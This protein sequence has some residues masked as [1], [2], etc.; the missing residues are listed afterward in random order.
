MNP[1]SDITIEGFD[2]NLDSDT[3]YIWYFRATDPQ[4]A[5]REFTVSLDEVREWISDNIDWVDD[6][7][8]NDI[9]LKEELDFN[10]QEAFVEEWLKNNK[11]PE[12]VYNTPQEEPVKPP[13]DSSQYARGGAIYSYSGFLGGVRDTQQISISANREKGTARV[14]CV[15]EKPD[16]RKAPLHISRKRMGDEVEKFWKD[17]RPLSTKI[18]SLSV[19]F[20][21]IDWYEN[22]GEY[23][24]GNDGSYDVPVFS[25]KRGLKKVRIEEDYETDVPK[26]WEI[27]V[28]CVFKL[29][30]TKTPYMAF[31]EGCFGVGFTSTNQ[32]KIEKELRKVLQGKK[33]S[34]YIDFHPEYEEGG[35]M[36]FETEPEFDLSDD[37]Y[38]I[39][40][41]KIVGSNWRKEPAL[42]KY[43]IDGGGKINLWKLKDLSSDD[44][45]SLSKTITTYAD[46]GRIG[47][48]I[49]LIKMEDPYSPVEA[50]TEGTI[51]S[52]DDIGQLHIDWDNGRT[53]AIVPEIDEYEL[54]DDEPLTYQVGDKV[55]LS[56]AYLGRWG[57]ESDEPD[58]VITYAW[59]EYYGGH[60]KEHGEDTGERYNIKTIDGN[61]LESLRE[62]DLTPRTLAKGGN[63]KTRYA[64]EADYY[65]YGDDDKDATREAKKIASEIDG[66]YDN[67]ARVKH[68]H[69]QPFGT[70]GSRQVF[71][72]GGEVAPNAKTSNLTPEQQK[73]VRSP[74]FKAWFG[75]SKVVDEKG[76]PLVVY[77]QTQEKFNVFDLDKEQGFG[78]FFWFTADKGQIERGE[79]GASGGEKGKEMYVMPVF[80]SINKI[81]GWNEYDKWQTASELIQEGYDGLKLDNDYIVFSPTQIK[82]ADG[83]NT[84][85]DTNNPDVRFDDG[86]E[87]KTLNDIKETFSKGNQLAKLELDDGLV[88]WFDIKD[89]RIE[90][91]RYGNHSNRQPLY[92]ENEKTF[93]ESV[94]RILAKQKGTTYAD[95]GEVSL[96]F[97]QGSSD[98][99]YHI[100]LEKD[101]GGYLV[102]FQYGRRGS[103][104]KSG[105]KTATPVSLP[106]AQKIYDKLLNSKVAKGYS[107]GATTSQQFSGNP[108]AP[109][110]VH[111]LPQLLNMVFTAKEFINDDSYLAQ[112]KMDGERRMVVT[113]PNGT[114]GLNKK[115]QEVPLPNK[116][117]DSIDDVCT[118][119]GEIIGTRLYAFDILELNGQNLEG[120]PCIER[121]STLNTLKFGDGVKVVGTAYNTE[122]KQELFDKLKREHREGIVF[123][124]KDAPYTHGRPH[125]GGNQLKY[126]FYKTATFIVA[127]ITP[128]KRSVGLELLDNGNMVF[129]GKVTI[130]PNKDI[131]NVGDFVEVRY[132]YAYK[133]GAIFQPTYLSKR[134]DSDLTDATI[135]QI[136]YKSD[137][138]GKGGKVENWETEHWET[139]S[140]EGD[141]E[142]GN[143]FRRMMEGKTSVKKSFEELNTLGER[144]P[145]VDMAKET[146][147]KFIDHTIY[148]MGLEKDEVENIW[149]KVGEEEYQRNKDKYAGGGEIQVKNI[150]NGRIKADLPIYISDD[151]Q[152]AL[153]ELKK[154]GY[155]SLVVGGA[156]RDALSGKIPKDIDIEVYGIRYKDLD[157][158]LSKYGTT[159]IVGKEFGVIK[160]KDSD[161]MEYD[162]S[163]PRRENKKGVGHKGF[164][165]QIDPNMTPKQASKRRDFTWNA[166]A[167]DPIGKIVYDYYGGIK[168]LKNG[169]MRATSEQFPEDS[170]RVLRAMQFQSRSG[171]KIAP[172]TLKVMKEMVKKGMME[173]L[174]KERVS[175]EW[176]K[177]ATKGE[178]PELIFSFL[179]NVGLDCV[180][181]H[182]CKLK[183]VEQDKEWHPEGD[184][185]I[186]TGLVMKEAVRIANREGLEG[187]DRAV[188]M[189]SALT[190]D[191]AK[192]HT[193]KKELKKVKRNGDTVEEFRITAKGHEK[194]GGNLA[195]EFLKSI[196]IKKSIIDRVVPLVE[197]HLSH[198]SIASVQE[199]K[200]KRSATSK[201]ARRLGKSN[202]DEL[203]L[204]IEADTSG[205]PPLKKG[206]P[207]SAE[208]LKK[209]AKSLGVQKE[210]EKDIILGRHLIELGLKP[211]E[212]FTPILKKVREAQETGEFE[213]VEQ[214]KKWVKKKGYKAK[215]GE[216]IGKGQKVYAY[217]YSNDYGNYNVTLDSNFGDKTFGEVIEIQQK[218]K[219]PR[220]S[221]YKI[222][223]D[224]D[225]ELSLWRLDFM[226]ENEYASGGEVIGK[227]HAKGGERFTVKSTGQLVELEGGEGVLKK[228][229]MDSEKEY[230]LKGTPKEIASCLN[231]EYDGVN[232]RDE[233][234]K[235]DITEGSYASGG[236]VRHSSGRK[237]PTDS[238]TWHIEGTK[239]QGNDGNIW[240]VGVNKN[241]IHRWVKCK[242]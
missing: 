221:R 170:L 234:G 84:T 68:L 87:I 242:P 12:L 105:T 171:N 118:I 82:L 178:H 71:D 50:G 189:F 51:R 229:A 18:Q 227:S 77:H 96:F 104:L 109:K 223:F 204:L 35:E 13:P 233:S 159:N 206:L 132:L 8:D 11:E 54:I 74:E 226:L 213:T 108:L 83:T 193:S 61:E 138:M 48:R 122:E 58:G 95:G 185:E 49:R 25:I 34:T 27:R 86:G 230:T 41:G 144:I 146:I 179:R 152:R 15:M 1:T 200:G 5:Y 19:G 135:E 21:H 231:E 88:Y 2:L 91:T 53:L 136:I 38:T 112:E 182:I 72:D 24:G 14:T 194:A 120:E 110:T 224:N 214:G 158:I 67:E 210:P 184:A 176:M 174:S 76:N 47:D 89:L 126:K 168:D 9:Y 42:K 98:K 207:K 117:I 75:D 240:C 150:K 111:R 33:D 37:T 190:H 232:F 149:Y 101:N 78:G 148:Y 100:Q 69:E 145:D 202:I 59:R 157:K 163:V 188:L 167:Y 238:A 4:D 36:A 211:G 7:V 173:E 191:F 222:R 166:L 209:L 31:I 64:A 195:K 225:E 114:M 165:V 60:T 151:G 220:I 113:T 125:S 127:N 198:T 85:F 63:V 10:D 56:P 133:G 241:G 156:V 119:D 141:I 103:A 43:L 192:P 40:L 187:D 92:Y 237:S 123:K 208:E 102:N 177:W 93:Y 160:F 197:N 57:R 153:S 29:T 228:S 181:P 212:R 216:V 154:K 130:P 155:K 80:L 215:G 73:L 62:T 116:I 236:S 107:Q 79:T 46:G 32:K 172:K 218:D 6:D 235:C 139:L 203:L 39:A 161:K 94:N 3:V 26:E 16:N 90:H 239:M 201:L 65:V 199:E 143:I 169:V 217:L 115:G 30:K 134:E 20:D 129:M 55:A 99:E 128:G 140:H 147:N 196:G 205:R 219:D 175:E 106:E 164:D 162:F 17:L 70:L 121:I 44:L 45:I 186:H 81:G 142:V 131:P 124:K 23:T 137:K 183:G 97:Q 180:L 28:S 66:K 52:V 22:Y